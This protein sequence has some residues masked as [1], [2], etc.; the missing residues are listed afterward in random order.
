MIQD[1]SSHG[2]IFSKNYM[3]IAIV[4]DPGHAGKKPGLTLPGGRPKPK[5]KHD[6]LETFYREARVEIGVSR[7]Q[8][9]LLGVIRDGSTVIIPGNPPKE[10]LQYVYL[11]HALSPGN[12]NLVI[13]GE[14]DGWFWAPF[15][16]KGPPEARGKKLYATYRSLWRDEKFLEMTAPLYEKS[17]E[18]WAMSRKAAR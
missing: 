4:D 3:N 14:T 15:E 10:V 2:I 7:S 6:P 5:D 9:E 18:V 12:P 8:M 1:Y 11:A 13:E 16:P 17:W